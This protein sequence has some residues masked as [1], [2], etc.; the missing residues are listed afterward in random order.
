MKINPSNITHYKNAIIKYFEE[1]TLA[2]MKFDKDTIKFITINSTNEVYIVMN[3]LVKNIGLVW[4]R[5]LQKLKNKETLFKVKHYKIINGN[6]THKNT[7]CIPLKY[8]PKWFESININKLKKNK[9]KF[10]R[11]KKNVHSLVEDF[12]GNN[13]SC[14]SFYNNESN[15]IQQYDKA[16]HTNLN[17]V[18]KQFEIYAKEQ[19][20]KEANY[21][22]TQVINYVHGQMFG[23][24]S[25]NTIGKRLYDWISDTQ[26][27]I[28]GTIKSGIIKY[29]N[30]LMNNGEHFRKIL[31]KIVETI[32]NTISNL[33]AYAP[34]ELLTNKELVTLG[35]K[36]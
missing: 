32:K 20:S 25:L 6:N 13:N 26:R 29:L 18:L 14:S 31:K 23:V 36:I 19:G 10:L 30:E 17:Y 3:P 12:L 35:Y 16:M 5:Q 24:S 21:Y 8:L 2:E 4:S 34:P 28:L 33:R 11:Y 15:E 9:K 22:T 7:L 1:Y 27:C